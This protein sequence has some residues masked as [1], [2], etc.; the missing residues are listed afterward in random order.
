MARY[1]KEYQ[2]MLNETV[3]PGDIDYNI[4]DGMSAAIDDMARTIPMSS[5]VRGVQNL[6]DTSEPID[7]EEANLKFGLTGEAAFTPED[8]DITI[9]KARARAEDLSRIRRNDF[10]RFIVNSKRPAL[11]NITQFVASMAVG[12]ADPF[13]VGGNVA[14]SYAVAKGVGALVSRASV[15]NRITEVSPT[16]GKFLQSAYAQNIN[17]SASTYLMREGAENLL[18]SI[19]EESVNFIGIGEDRLARKV[20]FGE[21]LQNIILGTGMGTAMGTVL[22]N[23]GRESL[24]R[25]FK[26]KYG[27]SAEE[28]VKNMNE[29]KQMEF[30]MDMPES[31]ITEIVHD[32]DTFG[33]KPHHEEVAP[34]PVVEEQPELAPSYISKDEDGAVV[35]YS[36]RDNPEQ[37]GS[38]TMTK[39]PHHA[40]NL[41]E[42]YVQYD[43][44]DLNMV[45][46][47]NFDTPVET[48]KVIPIEVKFK[49]DPEGGY[50]SKDGKWKIEKDDESKEWRVFSNTGKKGLDKWG[51]EISHGTKKESVA[52]VK[53]QVNPKD[54]TSFKKRLIDYVIGDFIHP[55]NQK[56]VKA[57]LDILVDPDMGKKT[58]A[59]L[60]KEL[61]TILGESDSIED[62]IEYMEE[63]AIR[64]DSNYNINITIDKVLDKT[65]YDGYNYKGKGATG[66]VAYDGV[67]I[68]ASATH[69]AKKVAER[70]TPKPNAAQVQQMQLERQTKIENYAEEID[71][72][73]SLMS[74]HMDNEMVGLIDD[75]ALNNQST[76]AAMV[77]GTEKAG[78]KHNYMFE[79]LELFE[80]KM[81]DKGIDALSST[82]KQE[83]V[84]LK[85]SFSNKD[86]DTVVSEQAKKAFKYLDCKYGKK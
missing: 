13:L 58:P 21:S 22:T 45:S 30:E 61:K 37:P 69:K 9:D 18:G 78:D 49:K 75:P 67:Y 74:S 63:M 24:L 39:S 48:K 55:L 72:Y 46:P 19:A 47:Q 14:A 80:T 51:W 12:F 7:Y 86:T 44:S 4:V 34:N 52:W 50:I 1:S 59:A 81:G 73:Q 70:V 29:V 38:V 11:G 28:L 25:S 83:Y 35:P 60:A 53:D 23:G 8:E 31:K 64:A 65:N 36:E 40:Q 26:R 54:K 82:D 6:F 68:K 17:T 2:D 71:Q 76:L 85:E 42:T 43:T 16:A 15:L 41:G 84:L 56:Q 32:E 10:I 62:I 3:A 57:L 79:Q 66:R 77:L 27:S 5:M 20:T 33:A